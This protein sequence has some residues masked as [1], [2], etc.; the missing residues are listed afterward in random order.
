MRRPFD[1]PELVAA[2]YRYVT[3][4]GRYLKLLRG[5][6]LRLDEPA[7]TAFSQDLIAAATLAT[8][9]ENSSSFDRRTAAGFCW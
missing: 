3:P 1:D 4:N 8:T 2:I 9:E 5:A 6:F 7:R